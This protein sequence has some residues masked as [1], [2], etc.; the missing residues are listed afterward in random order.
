M[1]PEPYLT[2]GTAAISYL[3]VKMKAKPVSLNINRDGKY[4]KWNLFCN[5]IIFSTFNS[6]GELFSSPCGGGLEYLHRSPEN[7]LDGFSRNV[8]LPRFTWGEYVTWRLAFLRVTRP[9]LLKY[10]LERK[11]IQTKVVEKNETRT[12]YWIRFSASLQFYR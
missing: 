3:K 6:Y 7:C 11:M 5:Y 10:L 2:I 8:I 4:F 1:L 9:D 12:M